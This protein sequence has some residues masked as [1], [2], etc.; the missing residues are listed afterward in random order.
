L[1]V[2]RS[3]SRRGRC[4]C[5]CST[6]TARTAGA[7][8]IASTVCT[9]TA[10]LAAVVRRAKHRTEA[11]AA[12]GAGGEDQEAKGEGSVTLHGRTFRERGNWWRRGWASSVQ[13]LRSEANDV[14]EELETYDPERIIQEGFDARRDGASEVLPGPRETRTELEGKYEESEKRVKVRSRNAGG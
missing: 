12:A 7:G 5:V 3:V 8:L 9:T 4:G 14:D 11:T 6:T 13:R 10:R 1:L 2:S